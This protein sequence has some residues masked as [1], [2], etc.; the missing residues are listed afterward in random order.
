MRPVKNWCSDWLLPASI[1]EDSVETSTWI[2]KKFSGLAEAATVVETIISPLLENAGKS[3]IFHFSGDVDAGDIFAS[4]KIRS[5]GSDS[6]IVPEL[7]A[8][9]PKLA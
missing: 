1:S 7:I 6:V 4:T 3:P 9:P 8:T 2:V 5:S